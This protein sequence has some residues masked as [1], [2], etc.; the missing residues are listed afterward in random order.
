MNMN[1]LTKLPM[2]IVV[3][4]CIGMSINFWDVWYILLRP[5]S[6]AGGSL[7]AI[8]LPYA[9]YVQIDTSYLDLH[10]EFI[11]SIAIA[12]SFEISLGLTALY[13]N[14]KHNIALAVV[15]AFSSLL[16]TGMKTILVFALEALDGF[17]HVAHN[18]FSDLICYYILPNIPWIIF[19][20]MAVFTLGRY[21]TSRLELN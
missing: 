6:F 1:K 14:N 2:W 20:F 3:W 21:I 5:D 12:N 4:L 8:W 15:L 16:L 11:K 9:K 7:G 17:T 19:P 13:F 10:N 18:P